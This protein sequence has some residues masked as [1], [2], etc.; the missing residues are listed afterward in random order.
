MLCKVSL[1]DFYL[2]PQ[3]KELQLISQ[4]QE[5]NTIRKLMEK[6]GERKGKKKEQITDYIK[7]KWSKQGEDTNS[8]LCKSFMNEVA[9]PRGLK[10]GA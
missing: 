3:N 9:F 4:Q 10:H 2:S 8:C 7:Y 5:Q 1:R 6:Y